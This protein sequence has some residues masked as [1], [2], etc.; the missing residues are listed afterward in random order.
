M[1]PF[2]TAKVRSTSWYIA[3]VF[4]LESMGA[5][6][7]NQ[8]GLSDMVWLRLKP[9]DLLLVQKLGHGVVQSTNHSSYQKS[10]PL[11]CKSGEETRQVLCYI[12]PQ[13][14]PRSLIPRILRF[15][16]PTPSVFSIYL[17]LNRYQRATS[18][19]EKWLSSGKIASRL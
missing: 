2:F 5:R 18:K 9:T 13:P 3:K 7:Q 8:C 14:T 15:G 12:I 11:Y 10:L 16:R 19:E 6:R 4:L 1:L 17:S